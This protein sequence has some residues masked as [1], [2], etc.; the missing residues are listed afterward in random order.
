MINKQDLIK[1]IEAQKARSAW[2]RGVKAYA[3]ELLENYEGEEV[4]GPL[5]SLENALLNG[6]E[7]WKAYS[8]GGCSLIYDQDIAQRLCTPSE[9]K[10]TRNGERRP[11]A[12]EEWLDCQARALYQAVRMIYRAY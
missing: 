12:R 8:W 1:K 9:L 10:I 2:A 11:N 7:N 3:L 5:Q 6:A 4:G